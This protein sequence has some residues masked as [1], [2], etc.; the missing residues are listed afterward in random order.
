MADLAQTVKITKLR[1]IEKPPTV[2]D[3]TVEGNN[4]LFVSNKISEK[5]VLVHNCVYLEEFHGLEIE[6]WILIYVSR[7]HNVTDMVMVGD[8]VDAEEKA[9][10]RKKYKI[11]D[12]TFGIAEKLKREDKT[13]DEKMAYMKKLIKYKPCESMKDYKAEF[14]GGYEIE[15][16]LAAKGTC[17]NST[18][19]KLA[20]KQAVYGGKV[21]SI[22]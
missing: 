5:S 18:N 22:L 3:I 19:L 4:N 21:K 1:K 11:Y 2:C 20:V 7:D 14:W 8:K 10:L 16:P 6:G 13:P 15:C 12:Y 9:K 17:F